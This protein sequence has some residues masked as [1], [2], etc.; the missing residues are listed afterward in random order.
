MDLEY[1]DKVRMGVAINL[2]WHE[3]QT[4]ER[5]LPKTKEDFDFIKLRAFEIK[6]KYLDDVWEEYELKKTTKEKEER[7]KLI[8]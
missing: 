5:I 3:Q 8:L 7:K 4:M 2:A 6:E 1:E